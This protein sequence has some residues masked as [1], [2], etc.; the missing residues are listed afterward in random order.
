M[1][2][3]LRNRLDFFIRSNIRFGRQVDPKQANE[4]DAPLQAEFDS[5][6]SVFDWKAALA[7]FEGRDKLNVADIGC[8]TF[9]YAPVLER[10]FAELGFATALRTCASLLP[11]RAA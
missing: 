5:Y 3:D 9:L 1:L 11:S 7:S 8:R 10:R 2:R 6:F 4:Q